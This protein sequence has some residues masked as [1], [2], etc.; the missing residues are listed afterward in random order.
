MTVLK[1]ALQ[2]AHRWEVVW[3]YWLRDNIKALVVRAALVFGCSL[4]LANVLE[5]AR[6]GRL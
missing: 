2:R 5:L 4:L 6:S 3:F 1:L